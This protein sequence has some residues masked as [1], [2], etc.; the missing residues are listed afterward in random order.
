MRYVYTT[1]KK[2][3][4]QEIVLEIEDGI[5]Q[6]VQFIGG[7][8]GNTQGVASLVVGMKAEDV[9]ARLQNIQ[10]GRRGSS[11]PAELAT[12]IGQALAAKDAPAEDAGQQGA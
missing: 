2:V 3:C 6:K 11:C 7:C 1:S 8:A 9:I 4:S 10:C 12:A 5:V